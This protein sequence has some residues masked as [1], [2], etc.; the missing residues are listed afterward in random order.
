MVYVPIRL[1]RY[2]CRKSSHQPSC[3]SNAPSFEHV[4]K[5]RLQ[6]RLNT[7]REQSLPT[8][9]VA[10]YERWMFS[11]A[12]SSK[13]VARS[14]IENVELIRSHMSSMPLGRTLNFMP[15][16]HC[17]VGPG[18]SDGSSPGRVRNRTSP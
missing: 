7:H 2:F 5:H 15:G 17:D 1:L 3:R 16:M 6:F 8:A 4:A 10:L 12:V 9:T 13:P 18:K 14:P 11:M